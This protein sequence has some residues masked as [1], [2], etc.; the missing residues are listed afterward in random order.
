M[1]IH[2]SLDGTDF[3][4]DSNKAASNVVDHSGITFEQ[5]AEVFFDPFFRLVDATRNGET[6][7]AIIGFDRA[8]RLLFVV[9]IQQDNVAIRIISAR[10][11]TK[12]ERYEHEHL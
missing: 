7:D 6:R 12:P 1:D 5:A 2:Y 3:V 11:A 9:H 10:K 4:W 8:S